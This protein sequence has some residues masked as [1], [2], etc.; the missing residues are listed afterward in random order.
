[1]N[2]QEARA[3]LESNNIQ[4]LRDACR[5]LGNVN[6]F[7]LLSKEQLINKL[8]DVTKIE[9]TADGIKI[10]PTACV[11]MKDRRKPAKQKRKLIKKVKK[12]GKRGR[13]K[14]KKVP[15][16]A[17]KKPA[18]R[19][20]KPVKPFATKKISGTKALT[21]ASKANALPA[22]KAGRRKGLPAPEPANLGAVNFAALP[23]APTENIPSLTGVAVP[24]AIEL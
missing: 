17:A 3:I 21:Q 2:K 8:L 23:D 10:C 4:T 20:R 16:K 6:Q 11:D 5:K 14:V 12:S 7:T 13:T 15:K 1:M 24:K 9:K 19:G 18:K 22:P